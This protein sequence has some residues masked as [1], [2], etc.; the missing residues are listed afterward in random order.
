LNSYVYSLR[1]LEVSNDANTLT[2][3]YL[4]A[5]VV[6]S[7]S[8]WE[9]SLRLPS[10]YIPSTKNVLSGFGATYSSNYMQQY[11]YSGFV[12]LQAKIDEY[13]I[14]KAKGLDMNTVKPNGVLQIYANSFPIPSQ[15]TDA[16]W[17]FLQNT[18]TLL[19]VFSV[20]IC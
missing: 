20:R 19:L 11:L 8:P 16:F 12:A 4:A 14:G 10:S 15:I 17:S 2:G 18:L 3:P 7:T 6:H 9:Y 13:I 5:I 1:V